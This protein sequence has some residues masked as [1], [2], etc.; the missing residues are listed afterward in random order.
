[1]P[2]VPRCGFWL[3]DILWGPLLEQ[4]MEEVGKQVRY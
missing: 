4:R 3:G 2:R 1:M